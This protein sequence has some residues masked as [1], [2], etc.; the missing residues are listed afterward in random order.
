M[1]PVHQ[2]WPRPSCMAQWKGEDDKA[3]RGR[4]GKTTSG[5]GQAWS[6]PSLRGQW[7]TEKNGGNWLWNHCGAQWPSQLRD[8]WWW[9]WWWWEAYSCFIFVLWLWSYEFHSIHWSLQRFS[10][11]FNF[12]L[13]Q[14][15]DFF[16]HFWHASWV[17]SKTMASD[18]AIIMNWPAHWMCCVV[19]FRHIAHFTKLYGTTRLAMYF[20]QEKT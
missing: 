9:W 15:F 3:D 7:R 10:R 16:F 14:W 18:W 11:N 5:D 8:R 13:S 4:D 12:I 1:S 17:S 19:S 20:G 6:L 2:V